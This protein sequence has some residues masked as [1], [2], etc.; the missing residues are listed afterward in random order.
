MTNHL[1]KFAE[2]LGRLIQSGF[3]PEQFAPLALELFSRQ[4]EK[5]EPYRKFCKRQGITPAGLSDWTLVPAMPTTAFKYMELS[6][7]SAPERKAVFYSS[8]TTGQTAG[9]HFHGADS[10][11]VYEASLW[12]W[13]I[14]NWG[15][16]EGLLVLTPGRNVA[17]HSSLVHMFD[18][19][20]QRGSF[21]ETVFTGVISPDG[22]W[23]LDFPAVL[24]NLRQAVRAGTPVNLFGT[25]FSFVH[26][27][28]HLANLS[29]YFELPAGSRVL[30]TGGYKNRS[31]EL[32]KAELHDLIR[33]QL[34]INPGNIICEYGMSELSSQAYSTGSQFGLDRRLG[35]TDAGSAFQFP[36]W[37]RVRIISPETGEEVQ[38]GE[39]GL[40][41]IFD[42]ANVFS[43]AAI[44]TE[45]VGVRRGNGFELLGRAQLA[46]PR[47]CSLMNA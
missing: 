45:D 2:R 37:A 44:Q 20:R 43:V 9:R 28:D 1:A 11:P 31:R 23:Q 18:T 13:F 14:A 38:D 3:N 30:E 33:R 39:V 4:Y 29:L 27:L 5:N 32:P 22:A 21:P 40:I 26:L 35:H 19:I 46:E 7:L 47:G 36:P 42:L 16:L 24:E 17:P 6:C 12:H 34:G 8:G 15:R 41:R 10:L 25:A